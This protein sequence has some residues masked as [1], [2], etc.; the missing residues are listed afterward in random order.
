M[1]GDKK[2]ENNEA[3]LESVESSLKSYK[4]IVVLAWKH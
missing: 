3:T 2:P 1:F 4:K